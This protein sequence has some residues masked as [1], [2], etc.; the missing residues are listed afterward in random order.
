MEKEPAD[1]DIC[2]FSGRIMEERTGWM[3][4]NI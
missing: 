1:L 2:R 4:N 3:K